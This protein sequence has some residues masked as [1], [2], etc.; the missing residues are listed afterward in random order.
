MSTPDPMAEEVVLDEAALL[1]EV[2]GDV[3][4]LRDRVDGFLRDSPRR[5]AEIAKALDSATRRMI[6]RE[7][8][9]LAESARRL[10]GRRAAAAALRLEQASQT[11]SLQEAGVAYAAVAE[12]V[13][14]LQLALSDLVSE[15]AAPA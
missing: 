4:E 1:A 12:E 14:K 13:R 11:G 3:F 10:S 8:H 15:H 7:A 5:L 9:T 6:E 2:G